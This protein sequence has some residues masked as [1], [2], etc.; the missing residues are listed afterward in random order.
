MT[1]PAPAGLVPEAAAD[2]PIIKRWTVY[3]ST[4][5]RQELDGDHLRAGASSRPIFGLRFRSEPELL[6][7]S[8]TSVVSMMRFWPST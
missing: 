4:I 2:P 3:G 6:G 7:V 5:R 1:S 8:R